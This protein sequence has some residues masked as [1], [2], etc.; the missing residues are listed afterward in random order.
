MTII[1]LIAKTLFALWTYK[2]KMSSKATSFLKPLIVDK[3]KYSTSL[4]LSKSYTSG[5]LY[6]KLLLFQI[7][8]SFFICWF[9]SLNGFTQVIFGALYSLLWVKAPCG[10][11]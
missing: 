9:S 8:Y 10:R 2:S 1:F 6:H 11:P 3:L 5:Q 7:P 4:L